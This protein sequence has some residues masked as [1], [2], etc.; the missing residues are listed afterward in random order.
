MD[1]MEVSANPITGSASAVTGGQVD[2]IA[3]HRSKVVA[4]LLAALL[5]GV[6]AH[7]WY[8]GRPKAWLATAA[9]GALIVLSR[10]YPV[11]W[12]NTPFLLLII[13]LTAGYIDALVICLRTDEQFDA[14]YNPHSGRQTKTRLTPI[15]IALAVTLFGFGIVVL[16]ISLIVMHVY[17]AMGWLDGYVY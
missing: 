17:T 5:G 12:D 4:A 3:P 8:I 6:C 16:F 10:F 9:S 15:L 14:R 2:G 13:P 11:W 1:P 7:W